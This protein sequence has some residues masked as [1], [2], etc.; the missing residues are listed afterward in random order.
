MSYRSKQKRID[1]FKNMRETQDSNQ[2]RLL[3]LASMVRNIDLMESNQQSNSKSDIMNVL[4]GSFAT[5]S[6]GQVKPTHF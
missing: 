4:R 3:K 2:S 6:T 1:V 5:E